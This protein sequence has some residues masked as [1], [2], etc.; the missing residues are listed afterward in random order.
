[1]IG[2]YLEIMN[3]YLAFFQECSKARQDLVK[4]YNLRSKSDLADK[5]FENIYEKMYF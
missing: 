2:F 1:V 4:T 3:I 5:Q